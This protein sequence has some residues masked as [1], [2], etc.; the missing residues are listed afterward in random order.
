MI[1]FIAG[2][3]FATLGMFVFAN[4]IGPRTETGAF[5]WW[6][7]IFSFIVWGIPAIKKN[8]EE[9]K[10]NAAHSAWLVEQQKRK[11]EEH[12]RWLAEERARQER[13]LAFLQRQLELLLE[14]KRKGM[15][16]EAEALEL[17]SKFARNDLNMFNEQTK[18]MMETMRREGLL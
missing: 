15:L 4:T 18:A 9:S 1:R 5:V 3:F 14:Y 7:G 6:I 12:A 16:I 17:Q 2:F 13:E 10:A 8:L 11:D